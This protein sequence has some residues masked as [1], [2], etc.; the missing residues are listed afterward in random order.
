MEN[1]LPTRH[2]L[3]EKRTVYVNGQEYTVK[4]NILT[5]KENVTIDGKEYGVEKGCNPLACDLPADVV[6]INGRQYV[7]RDDMMGRMC[8]RVDNAIQQK[9][10]EVVQQTFNIDA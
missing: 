3:P 8:D 2:T 10:A 4:K 1:I 6:V 5:G 9:A 7:V